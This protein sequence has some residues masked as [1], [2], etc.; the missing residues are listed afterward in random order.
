MTIGEI[1]GGPLYGSSAIVGGDGC[2]S[3]SEN[4][5][6]I[7]RFQGKHVAEIAKKLKGG[8]YRGSRQMLKKQELGK[9]FPSSYCLERDVAC[10]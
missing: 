9:I 7:A 10:C 2:R 3:P 5:F 1:T 6:A 4:E 8:R